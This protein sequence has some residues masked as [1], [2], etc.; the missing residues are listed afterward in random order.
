MT[1]GQIVTGQKYKWELVEKLGEGDAGEVYRV[2][3]MLKNRQAILKRP[4]RTAFISDGLRQ[5]SQIQSEASLLK[6]L[7]K[8]TFSAPGVDLVI[9]ALID[10][11]P[12]ADGSGERFFMVIEKAAG[13][14]LKTL[15]HVTRYG[16]LD[17]FQTSENHIYT[18]FLQTLAKFERLPEQLLIRALLAVINLL[19]TIHTGEVW[20]E[21]EKRRGLI[22][23]DIKPDH[24]FWD[25]QKAS[26]TVIDW[27]NGFFLDADGTT[28]DRQHS[29]IDDDVQFV[30]AI[31]EFLSEANPALLERLVWPASFTPGDAY[32]GG[33]LPLKEKLAVLNAEI[34]DQLQDLSVSIRDLYDASRPTLQD[35][36]RSDQLRQQLV[37]FGELPD[38]A[39]AQ[40]FY[41]RVALQLAAAHQFAEFQNLCLRAASQFSAG[42]EKWSL[43]GE[44][45]ALPHTAAAPLPENFP[46]ALASALA[47][48]VVDE[49]PALLWELFESLRA[50]PVPDWWETI[51]R[52]V[53]RI[54][55]KLDPDSLPPSVT[56][57]RLYYTLQAAMQE[58][59]A[60]LPAPGTNGGENG[61]G[62]TMP[63][64]ENP[65]HLLKLFDSEV[66][67]K[68][69]EREPAPPNSGIGYQELAA[70]MDEVDTR[71]P[72]SA[73][74]LQLALNQPQAQAAIVLDA[75]EH[76]DFETA[77]KAL[78]GLLLWDPDR[79][80]LLA[81]DY[82]ISQ[83]GAWLAQVRNGAPK[84]EP[85]Y[86]F[87]SS[88]ELAGR[89]LRNR[90]GPAIWLDSILNGLRS[91]RK[92]ARSADLIVN[93][94]GIGADLPWLNEFRS[95]ETLSLPHT[96]PLTL[97]RDMNASPAPT[98]IQ[99]SHEARFGHGQEV[100]LGEPLDTW[101]PEARGSSA[102]VFA[103][104]LRDRAG[105]DQSLAIK[106]MRPNRMQY[107][108]P[109]FREEAQILSLLRGVPG[110]T[111]LVECGYLRLE[112][113]AQLPEEDRHLSAAH[114]QGQAVRF[115]AEQVQNYLSS[116]D[117][118]LGQDWIPY[119][120]LETRD[121]NLNLL[122]YCDVGNTH[123]W[124]L[125]LRTGL[126]LSIQI[127]DILQTAHDRNI[128][129]RDH[130]ILHYYWDPRSHGVIS[131]DWNIA[132]RHAEGLTEPERQFDLVQFGARALHHILTGRPAPGAL[133]LGPNRPEE[134][135]AA[136]TQYTVSWTYDDERLPNQVKEILEKVLNQGYAQARDLR[137]DLAALYE[138]LPATV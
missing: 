91:L 21:Q 117:R 95:R 4:S 60:R 84:D 118:Y 92:G 38:S 70:I 22:W 39:R 43:L 75:W 9:P 32:A 112:E 17:H 59:Q 18:D 103:G 108:L 55:L 81:A 111:P 19:E 36:S 128:V 131:I 102:R 109:L 30:Q 42:S 126:L 27:G 94:P 88:I 52:R 133:P 58:T 2:E 98:T 105:K 96:R 87:L 51:S 13:F 136:S 80:R 64:L 90:V 125:P 76:R 82:A 122:K 5:A 44:I 83:A 129:Y 106:I 72:G 54:H 23:N 37:A 7:S 132:K 28:R 110:V 3:A 35:L 56:I 123:G 93:F 69:K 71:L 119:L 73:Q 15:A 29:K 86:D 6:A 63:L 40:N 104:T 10:Q 14:D 65:E 100:A 41:T 11:S 66:V 77:R 24:L 61:R 85:F 46:A 53:R 137:T 34:L 115:G 121:Q 89:R 116:M 45:A 67:K 130:K 78:R 107:A 48:G 20:D 99:G 1:V 26:L 135:E 134:I 57:S 49:W 114:L 97:E 47:S 113:G 33:L 127:C 68:W 124:F 120:A 74:K 79:W 50:A 101:V 25:P 62:A 138:Q 12:A 31:G 16:L 8:L